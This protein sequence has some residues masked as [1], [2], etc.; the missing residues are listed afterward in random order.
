LKVDLNREWLNDT[1][2]DYLENMD[3]LVVYTSDLTQSFGS[4]PHLSDRIDKCGQDPHSYAPLKPKR[5][6]P[7]ANIASAKKRVRQT[8]KRN[9]QNASRRSMMRAY[10]KKVVTAI[11]VKDKEKATE[12][13]KLAVP[14]LDRLARQGLIHKNKAARH[15]SRLTAQI[16]AL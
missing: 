13:Y 6:K 8:V 11:D 4:I 9:S 3:Y 2:L 12:A 5:N 7:L 10:L 15:K 16:Q 14:Q 1:P